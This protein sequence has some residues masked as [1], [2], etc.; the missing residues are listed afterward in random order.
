MLQ[1]VPTLGRDTNARHD[2]LAPR[3]PARTVEIAPGPFDMRTIVGEPE[4]WL[5]ILVLDGF[6]VGEVSTGRAHAAWLLGAEDLVRPSNRSE[7]A[8][9]REVAWEAPVPCRLALLDTQFARR[10][11]AIPGVSS[12]LCAC[13]QRTTDW[14]LAKSLIVSSPLIEER[15]LLLFAL[16]GERWAR[17]NYTGVHLALPL[18]HSLIGRLVSARRPSVTTA[19]KSLA[20]KGLVIREAQESWLLCRGRNAERESCWD[21]Y[22]NALGLR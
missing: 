15:V 14:L 11:D 9:T 13:G 7:I 6:L 2:V 10:A 12:A 18:T 21:Q 3:L 17:V 4:G 8:L 5:G 1:V 16:L 22:A 19:L 20:D